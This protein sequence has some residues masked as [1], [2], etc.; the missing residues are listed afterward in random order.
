MTSYMESE[1]QKERQSIIINSFYLL[2]FYCFFFDFLQVYQFYI[3]MDPLIYNRASINKNHYNFY[4]I[5]EEWIDQ[6]QLNN[7]IFW[8]QQFNNNN[9]YK[10]LLMR[11]RLMINYIFIILIND[12]QVQ[13]TQN[14]TISFNITRYNHFVSIIDD[15]YIQNSSHEALISSN[16]ARVSLMSNKLQTLISQAFFQANLTLNKAQELYLTNI[17]SKYQPTSSYKKKAEKGYLLAYQQP[18]NP[19]QIDSTSNY[20]KNFGNLLQLTDSFL[21]SLSLEQSSNIQLLFRI[22]QPHIASLFSPITLFST[23]DI[24]QRKYYI[25]HLQQNNTRYIGSPFIST[26]TLKV[27][28]MITQTFHNQDNI[29]DLIMAIGFQ[30][31][32]LSQYLTL[33]NIKFVLCTLSGIIV[34]SNINT[35]KVQA[36]RELTLIFN[37]TMF[38]FNHDDWEQMNKYLKNQT[39]QSNCKHSF[40][41]FCRNLNGSDIQLEPFLVQNIFI[42]IIFNDLSFTKQEQDVLEQNIKELLV[43]VSQYG[44]IIL[45]ECLLI[46]IVSSIIIT[47]IIK[48]I[49]GMI[50]VVELEIQTSSLDQVEIAEILHQFYIKTYRLQ[51][52]ES[53]QIQQI[54]LSK[55]Q[56]IYLIRQTGNKTYQQLI[57]RLQQKNLCSQIQKLPQNLSNIEQICFR[58]NRINYL[59]IVNLQNK[60]IQLSSFNSRNQ[61]SKGAIFQH[62][63]QN[64][65]SYSLFQVYQL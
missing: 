45:F 50:S 32:N 60:L 7:K 64:P 46:L 10:Y 22:Q 20:F 41:K 26:A 51:I 37:Q 19:E 61:S 39:Y 34:S 14:E 33:N 16:D 3:D 15:I 63:N 18:Y 27:S 4:T 44:G 1:K 57:T 56:P 29:N 8:L 5:K 48:P 49:A 31:D 59:E 65:F 47:Q 23:F 36:F 38:P 2:F 58:E 55:I 9:D 54:T 62:T 52:L 12:S 43:I 30:F 42:Q 6:N 21:L 28:F 11:Q 53:K 24:E 13:K 25:E 35:Q 40:I 17:N